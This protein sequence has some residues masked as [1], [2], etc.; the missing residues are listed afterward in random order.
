MSDAP[1]FGRTSLARR[2]RRAV[3]SRNTLVRGVLT[4]VLFASGHARAVDP[5]EIQVYDG[6]AS[7][8]GTPG[9]ELHANSV[10][11]GQRS[12][13]PPEAPSH[14]QTHLTLEPSFGL[15]P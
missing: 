11:R 10:L 9:L 14:H 1:A 3:A 12:A 4:A 6:T 13:P 8:P 5:F 7:A 2:R 15:L